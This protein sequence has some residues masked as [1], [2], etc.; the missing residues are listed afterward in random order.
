MQKRKHFRQKRMSRLLA[1]MSFVYPH[2]FSRKSK[3]FLNILEKKSVVIW[4]K[5]VDHWLSL[6]FLCVMMVMQVGAWCQDPQSLVSV[7]S[8]KWVSGSQTLALSS[9]WPETTVC[10]SWQLCDHNFHWYSW[11]F[12]LD[13]Q[14]N[15]IT[16]WDDKSW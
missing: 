5:I 8:H 3:I 4:T 6:I 10:G 15:I 7:S 2:S 13:F 1:I 9:V 16:Q 12:L 14:W 11:N